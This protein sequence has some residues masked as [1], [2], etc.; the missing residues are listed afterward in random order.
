MYDYCKLFFGIKEKYISAEAIKICNT[1][2][3]YIFVTT[4]FLRINGKV[5]SFKTLLLRREGSP[6]FGAVKNKCEGD[7]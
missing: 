2:N 1:S 3:F 4:V 7:R 6:Y 5:F